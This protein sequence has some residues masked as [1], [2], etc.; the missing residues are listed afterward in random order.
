MF[1]STGLG[2]AHCFWSQM[3]PLICCAFHS[4]HSGTILSHWLIIRPL[5]YHLFTA[6]SLLVSLWCACFSPV[7][8]VT[9][10]PRIYWRYIHWGWTTCPN[11]VPPKLDLTSF[12]QCSLLWLHF[13]PL[14][15]NVTS[16]YWAYCSQLFQATL[17][18]FFIALAS[19]GRQSLAGRPRS[20]LRDHCLPQFTFPLKRE[21]SGHEP[22]RASRDQC[23]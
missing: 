14:A 6:D 17:V 12:S 4:L 5:L 2:L 23:F 10:S 21:T 1:F 8:P 13:L 19:R 20:P 18:P 7:V 16:I 3:I 15:G 11:S 9:R 22:R